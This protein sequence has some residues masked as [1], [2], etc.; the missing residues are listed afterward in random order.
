MAVIHEEPL[1]VPKYQ[2]LATLNELHR[3]AD[4][5]SRE[6]LVLQ[7]YKPRR[8]PTYTSRPTKPTNQNAN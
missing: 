7:A 6:L 2:C 1:I 4:P 5:T 3:D 8:I